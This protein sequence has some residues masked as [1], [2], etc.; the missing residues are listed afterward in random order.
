[1]EKTVNIART[2]VRLFGDIYNLTN[3][4]AAETINPGTGL[5]SGVSTFQTPTAIL[6]PRTGRV[7][8]RFIW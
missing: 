8:F 7:G 6:G 4:Y 5:S 1:V 2:K 3:Q